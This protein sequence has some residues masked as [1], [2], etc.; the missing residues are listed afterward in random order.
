LHL[1][2]GMRAA[3]EPRVEPQTILPVQFHAARAARPERRLLLAVLND[4]LD[5]YRKHAD[6]PGRRH[7]RLFA[8]TEQ[9]LFSD[10]V[11]WPFSF[12]NLCHA[13]GIDADWLRRRLR[14]PLGATRGAPVPPTA[15]S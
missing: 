12:M 2:G 7:R 14:S 8:E 1:V 4:A 10:D 6:L 5:T 11:A 9:W 15:A 13:L 3:V